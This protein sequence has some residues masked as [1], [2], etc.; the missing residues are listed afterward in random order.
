MTAQFSVMIVFGNVHKGSK[1]C[2]KVLWGTVVDHL[3]Y[4]VRLLCLESVRVTV[5]N[6]FQPDI[7]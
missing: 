4:E 6:P 7:T 3:A 5:E 2:K 1:C